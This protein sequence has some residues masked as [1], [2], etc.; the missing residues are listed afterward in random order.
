MSAGGICIKN[1]LKALESF[2]VIFKQHPQQIKL[3]NIFY[4]QNVFCAASGFETF[5]VSREKEK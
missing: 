4:K 5:F 1:I 2:F 3:S